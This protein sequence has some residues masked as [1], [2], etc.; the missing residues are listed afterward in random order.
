[1]PFLLVGY[2]IIISDVCMIWL[3][4]IQVL[5]KCLK[6][7]HIHLHVIVVKNKVFYTKGFKKIEDYFLKR[8]DREYQS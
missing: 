5:K 1:M 3:N 6:L 8:K 7:S 4:L 2:I